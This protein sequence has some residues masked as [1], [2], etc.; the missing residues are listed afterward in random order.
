M[1]GRG[2]LAEK[3]GIEE[4]DE[5]D[6]EDL[7]KLIQKRKADIQMNLSPGKTYMIY[8]GGDHPMD[9]DLEQHLCSQDVKDIIQV[10]VASY[11]SF[12]VYEQVIVAEYAH[13]KLVK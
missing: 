9:R 11:S 13:G 2:D 1:A 3:V 12:T 10:R 7:E 4:M 5:E 6:L 8:N